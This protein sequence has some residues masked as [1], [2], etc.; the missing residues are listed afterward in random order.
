VT[1]SLRIPQSLYPFADHSL[2]RRLRLHFLDEGKGEPV[3]MLHGN[4]T[5]S[6]HFR[7]LVLALRDRYRV[8]C[9]TTWAW[10]V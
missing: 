8:V 7:A 3:V 9:P 5:W 4:P 6:L 10:A 1:D 2:I